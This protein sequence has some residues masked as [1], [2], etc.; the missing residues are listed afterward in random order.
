MCIAPSPQARSSLERT[1]PGSDLVT[2]D[3]AH[4]T[5]LLTR[6]AHHVR[7]VCDDYFEHI[8]DS[9]TGHR[10]RYGRKTH[11]YYQREYEERRRRAIRAARRRKK[12]MVQ[13]KQKG[14]RT[15]RSGDRKKIM[16]MM[17]GA[18]N[19][20]DPEEDDNEG[21][22]RGNSDPTA[23]EGGEGLMAEEDHARGRYGVSVS[24][25]DSP[26]PS[27]IPLS[28]GRAHVHRQ[29]REKGAGPGAS[30]GSKRGD[31]AAISVKDW[32]KGSPAASPPN[33][34]GGGSGIAR[35][36]GGEDGEEEYDEREDCDDE[37]GIPE[38]ERVRI[39]NT[40]SESITGYS[41][42]GPR[43]AAQ[44]ASENEHEKDR[45]VDTKNPDCK[46]P[47]DGHK[48]SDVSTTSGATAARHKKQDRNFGNWL[49]SEQDIKDDLTSTLNV[50]S[51]YVARDPI[52]EDYRD[53]QNVD[54]VQPS[55]PKQQ[56]PDPRPRPYVL[57]GVRE[58]LKVQ[59]PKVSSKAG[60]S[61]QEGRAGA[62][63]PRSTEKTG[64]QKARAPKSIAD[65]ARIPKFP[66][67]WLNEE[68][69]Q[70]RRMTAGPRAS[71]KHRQP[72]HSTED[73][74]YTQ[75]NNVQVPRK[76]RPDHNPK[77]HDNGGASQAKYRGTRGQSMPAQGNPSGA[78]GA[79]RRGRAARR[80][81][82]EF[83][84]EEF[85]AVDPLKNI[86]P[87]TE[88]SGRHHR[89]NAAPSYD[90]LRTS[91]F[92]NG[93]P[94]HVPQNGGGEASDC[95][96]YKHWKRE[97]RPHMS[98]FWRDG[99]SHTPQSGGEGPRAEWHRE[100]WHDEGWYPQEGSRARYG[101]TRDKALESDSSTG[102]SSGEEG[103]D[104]E[105]SSDASPSPSP[106]P[107]R[108]RNDAKGKQPPIY[109]TVDSAKTAPLDHYVIL[110]IS[111]D[112]TAKDVE[113]A[114]KRMRIQTHPDRLLKPGMA[115]SEKEKIKARSARV[116]QAHQ[117]LKDPAQR[118]CYDAEIREWKRKHGGVLPPEQI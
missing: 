56:L 73:P 78:S 50:A 5:S 51:S 114:G 20:E 98:R 3:H 28:S 27:E 83:M 42:G 110:G 31:D 97:E 71:Q 101:T 11:Q 35:L 32:A 37:Y 24:N 26:P 13:R 54:D 102:E 80:V 43:T 39:D 12:E 47:D 6:V 92:W 99:S 69:T 79:Q 18:A 57:F 108:R 2:A 88:F 70:T 113:V 66:G 30:A 104:G 85:H 87:G 41:M 100:E 67:I 49:V 14:E 75:G 59:Q 82:V 72:D 109:D 17:R 96:H 95:W 48:G 90:G 93:G 21:G 19:G 81:K 29:S 44:E 84:Y 4:M 63:E 9:E 46:E 58:T 10:D 112:A 8:E 77:P 94:S 115:E 16:A 38:E 103:E 62:T 61:P 36:D 15:E 40:D 25:H 33:L 34:R 89:A 55:Q 118:H 116:G 105:D 117:L 91:R 7:K 23:S 52:E 53:D 45:G 65:G 106:P 64:R 74:R 86:G 68:P 22:H 107:R 111:P 60:T 76:G 1:T